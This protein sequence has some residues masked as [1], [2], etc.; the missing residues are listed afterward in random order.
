MKGAKAILALAA[1]LL[2]LAGC[3][4][5]TGGDNRRVNASVGTWNYGG[6][7]VGVAYILWADLPQP[8]TPDGFTLT[9]T[10]PN[11]F[12][13]T[14]GPLR[15]SFSGVSLWW[16]GTSTLVPPTGSYT[17]SASLPGSL[18]LNRQ[19]SVDASRT[20]PQPQ[21]ITLQAT[22]NSATITW[23][24]VSGAASYIVELWQLDNQGQLSSLFWRW[25]TTG[26]QFQFTQ[27]AQVTL[28][29]GSYRARVFAANVDFTRFFTP[30]Q[31]PQLD[32]Q[33]LLSSA[34]SSQAVQV[35]STG[36]LRVMDLPPASDPGVAGGQE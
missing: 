36:T 31:A 26:T 32:P 33:V 22:S 20:L 21:N 13:W 12:S 11:N 28:P 24:S 16:A 2:L 1:V 18:N 30:G 6:Q 3:G 7:N 35:Q 15:N 29:A 34:L 19:M 23:S 10:G 5:Q 8:T 4:G 17:L 9:I 25:Y 14:R 27:A